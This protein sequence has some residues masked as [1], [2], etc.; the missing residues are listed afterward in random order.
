MSSKMRRIKLLFVG[1]FRE[2]ASI[3]ALGGTLTACSLLMG[4]LFAERVLP[5]LVDSTAPNPP[6]ALPMRAVL[7]AA[8]LVRVFLAL[9]FQRPDCALIFATAGASWIEKGVMARLCGVFGVP[10]ILA[11]RSMNAADDVVLSARLRHFTRAVIKCC[12]IVL[13]Q[14]E[15]AKARFLEAIPDAAALFRVRPNW[16][17]LD[18]YLRIPEP[19]SDTGSSLRVL[20]LGWL[21]PVKGIDI[22]VDAVDRHRGLLAGVTFSICGGGDLADAMRRRVAEL[23]LNDQIRF[24]GWVSGEGKLRALAAC[25][26]LVLPSR[27]EGMPNAVLEAMAS[28]RPVIGTDVGGVSD[29]IGPASRGCLIPPENPD[30]LAQAIATLAGDPVRRRAMGRAARDFAKTH[31]DISGAWQD[32]Y[33]LVEEAA[34]RRRDGHW[35]N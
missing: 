23:G 18:K 9:I 11:P 14:S 1:A 34:A 8:R 29:L 7:A 22:L 35:R 30:A 17:A 28:G 24:E 33:A 32:I 2:N 21:V 15:K 3:G 12:A 27:N 13:V 16:I 4:S 25:D 19:D 10:V 5:I 31:L 20:Y 26:V 6:Y